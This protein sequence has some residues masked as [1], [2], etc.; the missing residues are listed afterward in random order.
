MEDIYIPRYCYHHC[1]CCRYCY[2]TAPASSPI[3]LT[4]FSTKDGPKSRFNPKSR[5]WP[6]HDFISGPS[7]LKS[8][9]RKQNGETFYHCKFC[10]SSLGEFIRHSFKRL[11]SHGS[12][13]MVEIGPVFKPSTTHDSMVHSNV[14][15][16]LR[17]PH[18]T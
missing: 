8:T 17:A 14:H 2:S 16:K 5:S 4:Y 3:T 15:L 10:R 7:R 18:T 11:A 9:G 12:R 6:G 13:A 1:Y